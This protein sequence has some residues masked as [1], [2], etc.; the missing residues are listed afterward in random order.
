M[1]LPACRFFLAVQVLWHLQQC[2]VAM[3]LEGSPIGAQWYKMQIHLGNFI[4]EIT[5][6]RRF[7]LAE[8][9]RIKKGIVPKDWQIR[10][11][12]LKRLVACKRD[13]ET[14]TSATFLPFPCPG[15]PSTMAPS[16]SNWM[17][18]TS[19]L[20]LNTPSTS[21]TSRLCKWFA[22]AA[23]HR[24]VRLVKIGLQL[25]WLTLTYHSDK[26]MNERDM[27]SGGKM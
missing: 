24:A 26:L 4:L 7:H 14:C 22:G 21:S 23:C 20:V 18:Y 5:V 15:R 1:K 10:F 9:C 11:F 17:W 19:T 3:K 25:Q 6:H 27:Q 12:L 2:V 8:I 16:L 13:M